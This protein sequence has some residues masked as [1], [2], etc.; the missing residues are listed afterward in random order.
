M[1][2]KVLGRDKKQYG[3]ISHVMEIYGTFLSEERPYAA[4]SPKKPKEQ[5]R[6]GWNW[7]PRCKRLK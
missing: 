4:I 1:G 5:P 7:N 3:E 6:G 2:G